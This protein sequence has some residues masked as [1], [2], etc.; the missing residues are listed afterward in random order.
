MKPLCLYTCLAAVVLITGCVA[1]NQ[2]AALETRVAVMEQ[3][4]S[5]RNSLDQTNTDDLGRLKQQVDEFSKT[6]REN[7]AEVKYDIQLLK[8]DFHR[9]QGQL[10]EVRYKFG[11]TGQE[12]QESLEKRLERL[13]NAISRN[14]EKVIALEKYMGFEPSV[15]GPPGQN[16]DPVPNEIQD[17]EDGLYG[18]AKKLFD[19]GELENAKIQFENF[20]NKYPDS[21]NADN[22]RFWIADSYYA[23]KWYEKAILEYQKVLEDYPNSNKNAA[24]RLK[25]GYAFAALGEKANAR[26]I[27][28]E[29]ITRYP[30]SQEAKYA[31]E[32]LKNLN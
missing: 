1:P 9:I 30:N 31:K 14:Y 26:L 17:T 22:A 8:D 6:T 2:Y 12:R 5:R 21:K 32:K 28:K 19:Q 3:N 13:D 20:I 29:L 25:Q 16:N 11:I 10:E 7:Y 24:A 18:Y 23:E 4:N 15:S 27:L